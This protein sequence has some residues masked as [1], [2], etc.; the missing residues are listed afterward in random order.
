MYDVVIAG[1]GYMVRAGTYERRQ[2]APDPAQTGRVRLFD[3]YGGGGRAAQLERDRFWRGVGAWPA[4]DSQ[5]VQAGPRRQN[6]TETVTPAFDPDRPSFSFVHGGTTYLANGTGLYRVTA[7]GGTYDGLA[8]VQTLAA[9]CAGLA[10]SRG[11]VGF[12]HGPGQPPTIYDLATGTYTTSQAQ[13]AT[14]IAPGRGAVL[15]DQPTGGEPE[16]WAWQPWQDVRP[17]TGVQLD[18]EIVAVAPFNGE[19]WIVTRGAVWRAVATGGGVD[20][21]VVTTAP[22]TGFA[23]DFAWMIGHNGGLYAWLGKEVHRYDPGDKVFAP[24]GLRGRATYGACGLGRWLIVAVEDEHGDE[25]DLWAWDG[26]GWWLL[27]EGTAF[28]YPVAIAGPADDADVLAGRSGAVNQTAVWQLAPR[29]GRPGLRETVTLVT[30]LLDAGARDVEKVWRLVGVELA[31]PD[32]RMG[33]S[34]VTVTLEASVDGGLSWTEVA[35][36]AVRGDETRTHVVVG[37]LPPSARARWLQVRVTLSNVTDW[38]P[39]IAGIWAEYA[40]VDPESRR[41]RWTFAVQCKDQVVRRDG[42]VEQVNARELA[43]TLWAAW[44]AGGVVTFRDIDYDRTGEEYTVR[45]AAIREEVPK[46]HDAGRWGDGTVALTL[47]EV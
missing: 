12:V 9:P 45:I 17:G 16:L 38:C 28:R 29:A 2:S 20:A 4:L 30:P 46:P 42:S 23:D 41:R 43:R 10:V 35:A 6:R 25:T 8:L 47:V 22:R 7:A 19:V 40:A 14:I 34:P 13:P 37:T 26:R 27:D 36:S 18:Q 3:F 33:A 31:W 11:A 39:V 24:L 5:G 32:E 21:D 1:R 15:I 44:E